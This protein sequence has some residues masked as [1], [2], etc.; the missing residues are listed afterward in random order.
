MNTPSTFPP[1]FAHKPF[2]PQCGPHYGPVPFPDSLPRF[3]VFALPGVTRAPAGRAQV[4]EALLRILHAWAGAPVE[5]H[6]SPQGPA[7]PK[8]I[9]GQKIFI[10]IS[11]AETTAWIALAAD[12]PIG[13]D[14]V[15]LS[16]CAEWEEIA[17]LYLEED[18]NLLLQTTR[19]PERAF[20]LAWATL[21]AR[22]KLAGRPLR[23]KNPPPRA[24]TFT[25]WVGHCA[26]AVAFDEF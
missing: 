23:E 11:Y 6:D 8:E 2:P 21:E 14:A 19:T 3:V 16:D 13:L 20:A 26:L 22:Y 5:I 9:R 10:S 1:P 4:R 25:Q 12:A 7:V 24:R 18:T 17:A 15:S